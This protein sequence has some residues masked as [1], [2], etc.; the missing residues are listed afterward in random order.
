M[1]VFSRG[2]SHLMATQGRPSPLKTGMESV[3][4]ASSRPYRTLQMAESEVGPFCARCERLRADRM[5]AAGGVCWSGSRAQAGEAVGGAFR[6]WN[7][8]ANLADPDLQYLFRMCLL[9]KRRLSVA[10]VG[11]SASYEPVFA[12]A[13]ELS[14]A[15]CCG[16]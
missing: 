8:Q 5:F 16:L 13:S 10:R 12:K 3:V 4:H 15:S 11:T 7:L 1:R 2:L 9:T 14:G 6:M